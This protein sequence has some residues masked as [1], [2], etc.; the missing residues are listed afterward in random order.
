MSF[1]FH[2]IFRVYTKLIDLNNALKCMSELISVQKIL[3][4]IQGDAFSKSS[5]I[6]NRRPIVAEWVRSLNFSVLNH[7]IIS[8]L[9]LL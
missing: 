1:D 7:S 2:E 5:S 3:R 4:V 8:P 6:L 9:C